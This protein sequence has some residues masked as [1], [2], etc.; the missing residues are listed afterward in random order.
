MRLLFLCIFGL[1]YLSAGCQQSKTDYLVTI[2]TNLGDMKVIL[3]DSTPLHKENFLALAQEK[4]Y[5]GTIF[6]RVINK[7]MIQGGDI[8]LK[9]GSTFNG[10]S[11]LPA[12][13]RKSYFHRKGALA[14]AKL[15]DQVNPEKRSS[16]CQ[17]YIV[18][19]Q[20]VDTRS[21]SMD[22]SL[23]QYHLSRYLADPKNK[24]IADSL[25]AIAAKK[26]ETAYMDYF[27]S[28]IPQVEKELG[29][30]LKKDTPEERIKTYDKVGG[31]PHL[32]D[33]YTVFGQVVEG[34]DVVDK[35]AA[36]ETNPDSTPKTPVEMT[37]DVE[38]ISRKKLRSRYG[39][40]EQMRLP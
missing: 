16:N 17:F 38:K 37:M 26:S 9:E 5:D 13:I 39:L 30:D 33:Q 31:T 27:F 18:Q 22:L 3:Y 6:H 1:S 8:T 7:F 4:T 32:D 10:D 36:L 24:S 23:A 40:D 21:L 25:E 11:T 15:G 28:L 35:I 20:D 19:G 12:E 2:S 14:A 29:I 34:L